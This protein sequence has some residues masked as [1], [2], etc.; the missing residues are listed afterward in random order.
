[1]KIK[2]KRKDGI[3]KIGEFKWLDLSY[4]DDIVN[5]NESILHSIENKEI[6]ARTNREEFEEYLKGKGKIIGCI[7]DDNLIAMGVYVALKDDKRNYGYDLDLRGDFLLDV[8]QIE[9]T[10]VSK[11]FR[12]NKLQRRV[13]EILESIGREDNMKIISATASPINSYSVN[14]FIDLGY[15]IVKEKEKYGGLRRYILKKNI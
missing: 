4:L 5:L 13:C 11:E 3:E 2:L 10:V 14:T 12:G 7:V 6:Y 9:A 8:C 15:E 1:M